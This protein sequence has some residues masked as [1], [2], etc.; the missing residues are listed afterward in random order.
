MGGTMMVPDR[1]EDRRMGTTRRVLRGGVGVVVVGASIVVVGSTASAVHARTVPIRFAR[2]AAMPAAAGGGGGFGGL[3]C[4]APRRCVAVGA[5]ASG[6]AGWTTSAEGSG[7]WAWTRFQTLHPVS[8]APDYLRA[9]SCPTPTRCVAVGYAQDGDL[10]GS[11]NT[12]YAITASAVWVSRSWRWSIP[13]VLAAGGTGVDRLLSVSCPTST[14][15]VAVGRNVGQQ[16]IVASASWNGARWTWSVATA[17]HPDA[18]GDGELLSVS[19]PSA[20]ICVAVGD[21]AASPPTVGATGAG[22]T[23]TGTRAGSTWAWSTESTV[24][25]DATGQTRL[26]S[27]SCPTATRCDAVGVDSQSA[28]VDLLGT[29]SSESWSWARAGQ[30]ATVPASSPLMN[31]VTS[32][33]CAPALCVAV[34]SDP[35]GDPVF[36]NAPG[37][38]RASAWSPVRRVPRGSLVDATPESVSC[39]LAD[40]CVQVGV[41]AGETNTWTTTEATSEPAREVR[42]VPG[43]ARATVVWAPPAFDGGTRI[44]SYRATAEPGGRSCGVVMRVATPNTCTVR[45]LANGAHYRFVVTAH[46]GVGESPP[47]SASRPVTPTPFQPPIASPFTRAVRELVAAQPDVLTASV[48]DVLTG[49]SW[50]IDPSSVQHTASIVKV[51]ILAALLDDEQRDHVKM[52][53]ATRELATE[54]IEDSDNDAAQALYVE[55]GQEPGL[56]A[57]NQLIGLTGTAA[58]WAWGFTDT[59]AL[60]QARVVRL[61]ADPNRVLDSASRQF[62]LDLMRHVAASQ[63]WGI[64]SGPIAGVSIALK[65]GWY[66]T[67][68]GAWQVNSIGFVD[69]DRRD[70][71]IAVLTKDDAS[72]ATGVTAVEAVSRLLW[73]NLAPSP[74]THRG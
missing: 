2:V 57:F 36:A 27:V 56:A 26:T 3:S 12:G 67:M 10:P 49:Q 14:Q 72:F 31:D 63:A 68:P 20:R 11:G 30:F 1:S 32:V 50:T 62:G 17:A 28:G 53:S 19:C 37:P 69:G 66:P 39:P 58:N 59:T 60:D 18:R 24:A 74:T 7:V 35:A 42:A 61:F 38:S 41:A 47:S 65:N 13:T 70:Y 23:T 34:G 15:C 8:I 21:D 73:Q 33:S 71:V 43:N 52:P 4:P 29:M 40:D 6:R 16:G 64:S 9:V 54:M 48:Y 45:G 25:P 51:E 5:T 44:Q 55:V 46:N 22:V